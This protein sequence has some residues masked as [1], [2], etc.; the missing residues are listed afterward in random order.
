MILT[1]YNRLMKYT[2]IGMLTITMGGTLAACGNKAVNSTSGT[3]SSKV[4][5]L[6]ERVNNDGSFIVGQHGVLNTKADTS[7]KAILDIYL[8]PICP[9]CGDFDRASSKYLTS[10][11]NSGKL[12]IRY[13]PL[14][15]LD[16]DSTDEYSTRGSA[17]ML[18]VA[19]YAPNLAQK[20]MS[21]MY[22]TNFQPDEAKYKPV[23]NAKIMQLFK[24]IGGTEQQAKKINNSLNQFS[25]MTYETTMSVAKDQNLIKKSPTGQLFTP[26]ILANKPGKSAKKALL[27]PVDPMPQLKKAINDITK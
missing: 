26:F 18:A 23:S 17:F 11:V 7:K 10:K 9:S 15:F 12:L 16:Q 6:N 24:S 22:G 3:Q 20:F 8:D 25:N 13:H 4:V 5:K 19:E 14:M 2:A 27:L 1:N 21:A